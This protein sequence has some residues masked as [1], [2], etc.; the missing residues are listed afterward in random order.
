MQL[1]TKNKNEL[2]TISDNNHIVTKKEFEKYTNELRKFESTMRSKE[3]WELSDIEFS[4]FMDA[5]VSKNQELV[6]KIW[7]KNREEN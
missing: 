5:H 1:E 4:N 2:T 6:A 3:F 7:F